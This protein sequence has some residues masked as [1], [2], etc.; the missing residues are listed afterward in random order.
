MMHRIRIARTPRTLYTALVRNGEPVIDSAT[1]ILKRLR[2]ELP[3]AW[4]MLLA[5]P[6]QS[7]DTIDWWGEG[8]GN[9]TPLHA[10][11]AHERAKLLAVLKER[12]EHVRSI[13]ERARAGNPELAELIRLAT[14]FPDDSCVYS[15]AGQ[16]CVIF[17]G[18]A[19]AGA[20]LLVSATATAAPVATGAAPPP[21][22]APQNTASPAPSPTPATPP[23]TP[24]PTP[25]LAVP[26][27]RAGMIAGLT[28]LLLLLL[29]AGLA[30]W[31]RWWPV[32][33]LI[34]GDLQARLRL[35]D[36]RS[37][38]LQ[39]ELD[40]L[41]ARLQDARKSC[42]APEPGAAALP[43]PLQPPSAPPST[44]PVIAAP[45]PK[46]T[47]APALPPVAAVE[48]PPA[49]PAEPPLPKSKPT[50]PPTPS[51]APAP[52]PAVAPEALPAP[53]QSK[54]K[55]QPQQAATC[56]SPRQPWEAP[57]VVFALDAS[58]SMAFPFGM[59][60]A[61]EA[62]MI[63]GVRRGDPAAL[64]RAGAINANRAGDRRIDHAKRATKAAV[65]KLPGD[66]DAGLIV[67]GNCKSTDNFSFF[68]KGERPRLHG[69]VDG[70]QPQQ[71]TPLARGIER[72]ATMMDGSDP[73]KPA[74]IV[75]LSDGHDSCGADP[76]AAARRLKAQKPGLVIN[77]VQVTNGDS[78]SCLARETGG[79]VFN[80]QDVGGLMPAVQKATGQSP[81]PAE[82]RGQ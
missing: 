52:A 25:V 18:H 36:D 38:T 23:P 28:V 32:P 57:E 44:P 64:A 75:V 20:A 22:S 51:P 19:T 60:D 47:P 61:E 5:E 79:R 35:E 39:A 74:V 10:V 55:A 42:R 48:A 56:P 63:A 9:P 6:R 45:D 17:W 3:S 30:F 12:L 70:I 65:D 68:K 27:W 14:Q 54:P 33:L 21:V 11:P 40:A 41:E 66:V 58:G 76:C 46:P 43:L 4:G 62:A 59:S 34:G 24:N 73:K 2:G 67:F 50:P 69:I 7:V 49:A 29:F 82:C 1:L 37:A 53:A 13:A 81:I 31:L 26:G 16:P 8:L 77:V 72:A 15:V 80:A 71:G 78:A